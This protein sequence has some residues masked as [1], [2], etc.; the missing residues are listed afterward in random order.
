[1]ATAFRKPTRFGTRTRGVTPPQTRPSPVGGTR[2]ITSIK[3]RKPFSI[4][5]PSEQVSAPR[6]V[7]RKLTPV[8]A[9]VRALA[10]AEAEKQRRIAAAE[11]ARKAEEAKQAAAQ[12]AAA[13]KAAE[14]KAAAKPKEPAKKGWN[15]GGTSSKKK[16]KK[17]A[18]VSSE[19]TIITG[20]KKKPAPAKKK[21]TPIYEYDP[22]HLL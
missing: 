18:G 6:K 19:T 17:P 2:K 13:K 4:V 10:P 22:S 1:M 8:K 21:P 12:K 5:D 11:V 7:G 3:A 14:D 20:K 15:I 9:G 16:S